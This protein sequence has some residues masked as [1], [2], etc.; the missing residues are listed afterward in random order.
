MPLYHDAIQVVTEAKEKGVVLRLLGALAF[1]IHCL[2]FS[3]MYKVLKREIS[4]VDFVGYSKQSD[5]IRNIFA[6]LGYILDK[7][8]AAF[9]S[10]RDIFWDT[11]NSLKIDV[12]F[13]RLE[14]CH[15]I[16]LKGRLEVDFPT[17]PLADMLLEKMQIVQLNEKDVIDTL[18]LLREHEVGEVDDETV[19]HDYIASILSNDW[20]FYYT[21]T[22]NFMRMRD[23]FLPIYA[24][25]TEE[26]K[27]IIQTRLDTLLKKIEEKPKSFKWKMRSRVGTKKKWYN[28]VE[29]L[30]H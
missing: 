20:G 25:L 17:I 13:D 21:V 4:D 27:H 24:V 29:D 28:D 6:D 9:R 30:P 23:E 16:D 22:S 11:K 1:Q 18:V 14:M 12:F 10:E 15:T 3:S 19:N 5:G 2:K 26:D 8:Y 7:H